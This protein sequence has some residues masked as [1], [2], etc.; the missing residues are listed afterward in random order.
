MGL[1]L[2]NL[3]AIGP[4][5][6]WAIGAALAL[7]L[8]VLWY[9]QGFH[10]RVVWVCLALLGPGV[11][12]TAWYGLGEDAGFVADLGRVAPWPVAVVTVVALIVGSR[13]KPDVPHAPPAPKATAVLGGTAAATGAGGQSTAGEGNI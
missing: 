3:E 2:D 11:S 1:L 13:R 4:W 6:A 9:I 5:W 8:V 12:L 10:R 7:G